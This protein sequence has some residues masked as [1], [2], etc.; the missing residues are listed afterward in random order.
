MEFPPYLFYIRALE[1]LSFPL[2]N[3]CPLF[4]ELKIKEFHKYS[5]ERLDKRRVTSG[6]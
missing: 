4:V 5:T 2:S 6:R 3:L 1:R